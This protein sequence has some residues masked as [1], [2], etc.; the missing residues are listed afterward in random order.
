[1]VVAARLGQTGWSRPCRPQP[2]DAGQETVAVRVQDLILMR[3]SAVFSITAKAG[4]S[5]GGVRQDLARPVSVLIVDD[6]ADMRS[7]VKIVLERAGFVA[8]VAADGER[9]LDLQ[10]AHPAD[11]LITDIF[12]PE[13]DGIELIHQFKSAFPLVKIIAMSGGGR[14]SKRDYLPFAADLGADL[15]LR[16]P[17]GADALLSKLQALAPH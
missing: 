8:Q 4:Q 13:R 5:D 2:I 6:N 9:A 16:K 15:V 1:V 3:G 17:F 7:F 11:V 12:M 10:R 14:M